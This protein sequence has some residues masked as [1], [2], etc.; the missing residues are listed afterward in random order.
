[1]HF[2]IF[3]CSEFVQRRIQ[4]LFARAS[5]VILTNITIET[6]DDLDDVEVCSSSYVLFGLYVELKLHF[7]HSLDLN[8]CVILSMKSSQTKLC[9]F[10]C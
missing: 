10:A 8:T 4:K 3:S 1:M 9:V 5:S 7:E 2:N 6:L